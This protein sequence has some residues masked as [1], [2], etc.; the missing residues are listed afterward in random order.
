MQANYPRIVVLLIL[1]CLVIEKSM[2]EVCHWTSLLRVRN[3]A[4]NFATNNRYLASAFIVSPTRKSPCCVNPL[5]QGL[6]SHSLVLN[7]NV[8]HPPGSMYSLT[9]VEHH[10][11]SHNAHLFVQWQSKHLKRIVLV[12][13]N[14]DL[15]R[16]SQETIWT[17]QELS[18][19]GR[20][21]QITKYQRQKHR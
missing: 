6:C 17:G 20:P 15:T 4:N 9:Y 8:S 5:A 16:P 18:Q 19:K 11:S 3:N 1:L 21:N 7:T 2:V 12:H 14:C 13:V 10:L